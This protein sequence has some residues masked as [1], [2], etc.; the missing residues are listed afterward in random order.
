[1]H[2]A[3]LFEEDVDGP[4]Q[5]SQFSPLQAVGDFFLR[6]YG[7]WWWQLAD[8][9]HPL[10]LLGKVSDD[11]TVVEVAKTDDEAV[12]A[13][14]VLGIVGLLLLELVGLEVSGFD[15]EFATDGPGAAPTFGA[16]IFWQFGGS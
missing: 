9:E 13:D 15:D 2:V 6:S 5:P 12:E 1:V 3:L 4:A 7:E 11:D 10:E 8:D 16:G 14:V